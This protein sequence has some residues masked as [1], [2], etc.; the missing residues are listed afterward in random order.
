MRLLEWLWLIFLLSINTLYF[1]NRKIIFLPFFHPRPPKWPPVSSYRYFYL[2]AAPLGWGGF[3]RVKK[4]EKWTF[5]FFLGDLGHQI[6]HSLKS[7]ISA[8]GKIWWHKSPKKNDK[9]FFSVFFH[10]Q[11]SFS[12]ESKVNGLKKFLKSKCCPFLIWCILDS[13]QHHLVDFW[14]KRPANFNFIWLVWNSYDSSI[15]F[16]IICLHSSSFKLKS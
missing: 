7:N 6:F 2:S 1:S 13:T 10:W 16:Y 15:Q 12:H 5:S 14:K 4:T 3:L 8:W 11:I 9:V